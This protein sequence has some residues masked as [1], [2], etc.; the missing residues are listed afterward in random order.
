MMSKKL[1]QL[2]RIS[3]SEGRKI[4]LGNYESMDYHI[5]YST[6]VQPDETPHQAFLRASKFVE[7]HLKKKV[8]RHR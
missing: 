1:E 8:N 5:S 2:D 3:Y 7:R 4:N 6:D